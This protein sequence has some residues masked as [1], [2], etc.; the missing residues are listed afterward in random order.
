M[1]QFFE[2]KSNMPSEITHEQSKW[3]APNFKREQKLGTFL[4]NKLF[5]KKRFKKLQ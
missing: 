3:I 1:V 4:E 2:P 5:K